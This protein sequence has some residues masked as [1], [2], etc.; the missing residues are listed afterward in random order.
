MSLWS[1]QIIAAMYKEKNDFDSFKKNV[2]YFFLH[3]PLKVIFWP[4]ELRC[5]LIAMTSQ[6][7]TTGSPGICE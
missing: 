6:E 5:K 7:I 2:K 3:N 4:T 1:L